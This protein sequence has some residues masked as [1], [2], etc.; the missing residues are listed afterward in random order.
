[1][2]NCCLGVMVARLSHRS[3]PAP[4]RVAEGGNPGDWSPDYASR[5]HLTYWCGCPCR[6]IGGVAPPST[7]SRY[8]PIAPWFRYPISFC[9]GIDWARRPGHGFFE[10][11]APT[12]W[13]CKFVF[14]HP[15][16]S[17][18]GFVWGPV[19]AAALPGRRGGCVLSGWPNQNV[20]RRETA[21]EDGG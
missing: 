5:L 15:R 12:G 8:L 18:L 19:R 10:F 14:G 13:P 2:P 17:Q 4:F 3:R 21:V 6:H 20:S 7:S 9:V 16:G 11:P 1:M